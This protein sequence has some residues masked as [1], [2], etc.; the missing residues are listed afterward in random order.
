MVKR[1]DRGAWPELIYRLVEHYKWETQHLCRGQPASEFYAKIRRHEVPLNFLFSILLR[2]AD[3]V[4]I[5]NLLKTFVVPGEAADFNAAE[6]AYPWTPTPEYIQPDIRIETPMARVFV[7]IKVGSSIKLEQ[8]QRYL[9]LH[10]EMNMSD[11]FGPKKPYLLFLTKDEF[12]KNWSPA[13]QRAGSEHVDSFIRD[14]IDMEMNSALQ[15]YKSKNERILAEYEAVKKH[16]M[17]GATNWK[18]VAAYLAEI[19]AE[20]G[21]G[22]R[23]SEV[24]I[25]DDFLADLEV[26]GLTS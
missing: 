19:R 10:A 11:S 25:Y 7:E 6:V 16:V 24:R 8:V 15:F 2:L 3:S 18:S 9:L 17:Y 14:K 13:T 1:I 20:S 4:T 22:L 12:G 21:A 5:S 26:R 23:K